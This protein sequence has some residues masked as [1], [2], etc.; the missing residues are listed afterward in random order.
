MYYNSRYK[1]WKQAFD[2]VNAAARKHEIIKAIASEVAG[3]SV[4][5]MCGFTN[6]DRE[7]VSTNYYNT[8]EVCENFSL[9]Q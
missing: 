5:N 6:E 9:L 4:E 1:T 7:L 3:K 2:E 8:T